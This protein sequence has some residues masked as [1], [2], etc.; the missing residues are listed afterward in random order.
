MDEHTDTRITCVIGHM[1]SGA[2]HP[3]VVVSS[4]SLATVAEAVEHVVYS[5]T[6]DTVSATEGLFWGGETLRLEGF[7][8]SNIGLENQVLVGDS[9]CTVAA[10][11]F[12]FVECEVP[13]AGSLAAIDL[14]VHGDQDASFDNTDGADNGMGGGG[15]EKPVAVVTIQVSGG[16]FQAR[17]TSRC[18][19]RW[20]RAGPGCL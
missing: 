3:R 7:G 11:G 17:R 10:A 20:R 18:G 12:D 2:Y 8:F 14:T 16:S 19:C 13:F 4:V 1:K 5:L 9:L 15:D 6:I